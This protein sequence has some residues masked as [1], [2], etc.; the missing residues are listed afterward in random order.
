MHTSQNKKPE[1]LNKSKSRLT[2]NDL[3]LHV[4]LGLSSEERSALQEIYISVEMEF[5]PPPL[6]EITDNVKDTFCYSEIYETLKSYLKNK[7][8]NL[9]EKMARECLSV[10]CKKYPSVFVRLTIYKKKP[11]VEGIKGGVKYTCEGGLV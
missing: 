5:S 2:I 1:I 4:H 11:P 3:A 10:L 7:S 9:I 6:G 8:F